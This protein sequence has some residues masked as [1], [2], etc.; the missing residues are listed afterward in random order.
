MV[1]SNVVAASGPRRLASLDILRGLDLFVLLFLQPVLSGLERV[2]NVPW[3]NAVM[4]NFHHCK[5]EGFRMWDMVMPLFLFMVGTAMPFSFAKYMVM[6]DRTQVYKKILRRFVILFLFGMIV[7]GNLLSL[8]PGSVRIY[9]NTLQAIAV[10]YV[11]AAMIM[12]NFRLRWQV[13]I[14]GTLLVIYWI[15]MHF[16]GDYTLEGSFAYMVDAMVI[17]DFRGDLTYTWVWSSLN[18]GVSVMMG[19]FAGQ[20]IKNGRDDK[21]TPLW[22]ALTG[23]GMIAAGLLW[24]ME[25]PI[26][27][28]LWTSSMTLYAG[29]WSF[30]LMALFY[31]WIDCKGHSK[32]LNWL[33]I[34]GTNSITAYIIGNVVNFR[35][36]VSSLSYGLE[37]IL[38]DYYPVWLTFG[39][40]LIDQRPVPNRSTWSMRTS[41]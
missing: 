21:R 30:L 38:G 6:S 32:G 33:K 37:P 12:L 16:C 23:L 34:Y 36:V 10:G 41:Q 35:S 1:N 19:V 28:R 15:P 17:G 2:A 4:Y 7:Q 8:N 22:L 39:N 13:V 25:M 31:Y 11:I 29:G 14:A 20:M 18:F 5:W 27:K 3:L 26:I 9:T 24:S 40:Y